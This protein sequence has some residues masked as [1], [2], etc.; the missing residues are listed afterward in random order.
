[1]ETIVIGSPV[2]TARLIRPGGAGG[3]GLQQSLRVSQGRRKDASAAHQ[4]AVPWAAH[5]AQ[6]EAFGSQAAAAADA[7]LPGLCG[8]GH[9]QRPKAND[10]AQEG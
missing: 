6:G 9:V 3:Q 7:D 8:A 4:E 1:M 2:P 5:R 10:Q